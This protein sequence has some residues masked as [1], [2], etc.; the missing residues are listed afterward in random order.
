M[1]FKKTKLSR[2]GETVEVP[3]D[4]SSPL[5][6]SDDAPATEDNEKISRVVLGSLGRGLK[7]TIG[8]FIGLIALSFALYTALAGTLMF[9]AP[10]NTSSFER[11]VVA[12]GM[13]VG[14]VVNPGTFVYGSMQSKAA[15]DFFGKV[16]EGYVGSPKYFIGE[17]VAGPFGT[18]SNGA[19][20]SVLFNNQPTGYFGKITSQKIDKS[21]LVRCINGDCEKNSLMVVN[22]TN[23]IG[24]ARS[25]VYPFG[26][27]SFAS[28]KG[29]K[30]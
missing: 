3:E 2:N 18:I 26:T 28:A 11:V 12:R 9:A 20:D 8:V 24:E 14:G 21:Y 16:A 29:E 30:Q 1:V 13:F 23:M 4:Y 15:D 5:A 10:V 7:A 19:E 17:V 6:A 27:S 22:T 25:I